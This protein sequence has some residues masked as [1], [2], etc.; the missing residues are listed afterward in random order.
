MFYIH[1][2]YAWHENREFDVKVFSSMDKDDVEKLAKDWLYN[3]ICIRL[4]DVIPYVK[5]EEEMKEVVENNT[6][7]DIAGSMEERSTVHINI[8]YINCHCDDK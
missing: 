1:V 2:A 4:I 7:I 8:E 3:K 6:L 5:D